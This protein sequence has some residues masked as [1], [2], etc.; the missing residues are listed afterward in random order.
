MKKLIPLLVLALI[1]GAAFAGDKDK[2]AAVFET[3]DQNHDQRISQS[4]AA[5]DESVAAQFAA[6]DAN[7]DGALTKREFSAGAKSDKS[8]SRYKQPTQPTPEQ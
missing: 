4:E 5:G 1:S 6:L 7:G 2:A 3:L 8:D